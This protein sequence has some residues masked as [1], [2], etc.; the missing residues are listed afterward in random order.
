MHMKNQQRFKFLYSGSAKVLWYFLVLGWA[1]LRTLLVKGVFEKN[2]VNPYIYL[3]IDL[4]A[5]VPYAKYTH[6]MAISY[7]ESN[8]K[9]FRFALIVSAST[10][11]APDIYILATARHVPTSIYIGFFVVLAFFSMLAIFSI[12]NKIKPRPH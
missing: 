6:K 9:S 7:L 2:G 4:T 8:W 3:F 1:L 11:Y 12:L 10:F 5:S